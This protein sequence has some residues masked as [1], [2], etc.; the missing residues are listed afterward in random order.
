MKA[1]PP[2]HRASPKADINTASEEQ[3]VKMISIPASEDELIQEYQNLARSIIKPYLNRGIP[4]EGLMQEAQIG[5]LEAYRRFDPSRGTKFST[6]ASLWI[7]KRVLQ[8]VQIEAEGTFTELENAEWIAAP[9]EIN[10]EVSA[11][12]WMELASD[13]P[14]LERKILVMSYEQRL[15]LKEIAAA[16]ELRVEQVKQ[17]RQKSLRRI[18]S[19]HF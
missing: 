12:G 19:Q 6:Y 10:T 16:L 2:E 5:L 11:P 13:L 1:A 7:K 8:A 9:A 4:R 18:R 17:L 14:L 15:S 3:T